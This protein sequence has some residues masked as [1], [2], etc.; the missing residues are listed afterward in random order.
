[1]LTDG[2]ARISAPV[3]DLTRCPHCQCAN[4]AVARFCRSCGEH[5]P[6]PNAVAPPHTFLGRLWQ[7]AVDE[8]TPSPAEV[9]APRGVGAIT[10]VGIHFGLLALGTRSGHLLLY[11]PAELREPARTIQVGAAV[12]AVE[13]WCVEPDLP[14]RSGTAG[15]LVTTV[16]SVVHVSLLAEDRVERLMTVESGD[17]ILQPAVATGEG[18]FVLAGRMGSANAFWLPAPG[19][20]AEPL[21]RALEG[22]VGPPVQVGGGRLLFTDSRCAFCFDPGE[23]VLHAAILP[24]AP[25]PMARPVAAAGGEGVFIPY[26]E[27][28]RA[29]VLHLSLDTMSSFRLIQP[30]FASLQL[31]SLNTK[32]LCVASERDL[33]LRSPLNGKVEWSRNEN[34]HIDT[35]A[36]D[37]ITPTRFGT[38]LFTHSMDRDGDG[39]LEVM[40]LSDEGL[41]TG[42]RRL[43]DLRNPLAPPVMVGAGLLVVSA[44][45]ERG[46]AQVHLIPAVDL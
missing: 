8:R 40:H 1:M 45:T 18:V 38:Y 41:K 35:L 24:S 31:A 13:P 14:A 32:L 28:R 26:R 9:E 22:R 20:E 33:Q 27:E 36:A 12:L 5:F 21:G 10:T 34:L 3:P 11:D 42:P 17:T 37:R 39:R 6:E 16:N 19:A 46:A 2:A 30:E 25:D 7:S 15:L 44:P 43:M 29:G 23:R 4:P